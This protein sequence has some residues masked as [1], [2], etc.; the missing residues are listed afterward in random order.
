MARVWGSFI[1]PATIVLALLAAMV[2]AWGAPALAKAPA[3][4]IVFV[5]TDNNIHYTQS[6][7]AKP[8]CLTCPVQGMQVR[9]D[10]DF[11]PVAF[12]PVADEN[13]KIIEYAWPTFAPDGKRIAYGSVTR[14]RSGESYAVWVYDLHRREALQIYQSRSER[15]V[16]IFWLGDNRHISFL[17]NE[18]NGLSLMLCEVKEGAPIRIVMSG[19]PL[20]FD[21]RSTGDRLV[22][23]TAG[24]DPETS[25]RVAMIS[26]TETN[27]QVDKVL[28]SGRTPFKTPCWSPDGKRLAYIAN[29][30]AESNIVVA[31]ANGDHPRSIVSLPIGDN[32]LV[33]S[34]D[35]RHIAYATT[36]IP[37]DPTFHGIK[38]VDIEDASS[39][40]LTRD[41]VA[42]YFFSPDARY[43]AYITVPSDKPY[44]VWQVADLKGGK[45]HDLGRFLSTQEESI[46]YRFFDQLALSH[47][48]WSTDSSAIV[49]AGV[50]LLAEP[51]QELH[52]T[53]PPSVWVVPIDGS[54]PRQVDAGIVAF[55]A[56]APK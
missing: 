40:D 35:S 50:R 43:L 27:Q 15:V 2:A 6:A 52:S 20:Y 51:D 49:F 26:L 14:D 56:P 24:S 17:L 10:R 45:T 1:R 29:Y 34:P 22:V 4:A 11:T 8:E 48:I 19:V 54:Q 37:H 23:H 25:E 5:G 38:L 46:A 36:V 28:S 33:W 18:P 31:D 41:D 12:R 16:Y 39:R 42:A 9:R 44:Y 32:S 30:H 21:W 55:Y 47:T 7:D 53:P 3:G 13:P